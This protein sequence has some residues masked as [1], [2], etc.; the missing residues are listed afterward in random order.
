M[1]SPVYTND[2]EVYQML[3]NYVNVSNLNDLR[4]DGH[5]VRNADVILFSNTLLQP[6]GLQEYTRPVAELINTCPVLTPI[7]Y[8]MAQYTAPLGS[9]S[10]ML[11]DEERW[12]ELTLV[13]DGASNLVRFE[14]MRVEPTHLTAGDYIITNTKLTFKASCTLQRMLETPRFARELELDYHKTTGR[15]L[16]L[17]R[18]LNE[19]ELKDTLLKNFIALTSEDTMEQ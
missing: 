7:L 9:M 1:D 10:V 5:K 6:K 14:R 3:K 12:Y 16:N 8:G 15:I 4:E 18:P 2:N 13:D 17:C 11:Y 19:T